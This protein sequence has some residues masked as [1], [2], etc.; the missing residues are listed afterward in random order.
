MIIDTGANV[1]IMRQEFAKHLKGNILW[2]PP[3][4]TLQ[5]VTGDRIPIIGKMNIKIRFG[6]SSYEHSVF[7][8][9]IIDDFI[10]G[11]DR[12]SVV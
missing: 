12:K 5:T 9:E 10:L 6:N 11:L 2:T 7:V 4:V 3:C 8:A 1:T